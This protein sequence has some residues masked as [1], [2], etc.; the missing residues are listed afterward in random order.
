MLHSVRRLNVTQWIPRLRPNLRRC[1][2]TASW[3]PVTHRLHSRSKTLISRHGWRVRRIHLLVGKAP[4][5]SR[6]ERSGVEWLEDIYT[7]HGSWKYT[8]R[9]GSEYML[10]MHEIVSDYNHENYIPWRLYR[11]GRRWLGNT[12]PARL[13]EIPFFPRIEFT[14]VVC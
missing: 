9:L 11:L 14:R 6:K 10:P 5:R 3:A 8:L 13:V 1:R 7:L 12:E 4:R 2:R